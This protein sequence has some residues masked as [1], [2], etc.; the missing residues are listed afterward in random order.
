MAAKSRILLQIRG[1]IEHIFF[2]F[3]RLLEQVPVLIFRFHID[4]T[5]TTRLEKKSY[6][7]KTDTGIS[8]LKQAYQSSLTSSFNVDVVSVSEEHEIIPDFA[9]DLVLDSVPILV[10][11][12]TS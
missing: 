5:R 3:C 10:Y 8:V 11:F 2:V 9:S 12:F 4:M 7:K 6:P 1:H